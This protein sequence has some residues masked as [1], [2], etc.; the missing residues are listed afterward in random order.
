ME[1]RDRDAQGWPQDCY[2]DKY[3][4]DGIPHPVKN[5]EERYNHKRR[6]AHRNVVQANLLLSCHR[7]P[8]DIP[9]RFET[10]IPIEVDSE[11]EITSSLAWESGGHQRSNVD[12]DQTDGLD[13]SPSSRGSAARSMDTEMLPT[14]F[15]YDL[16]DSPQERPAADNAHDY[17][18]SDDE[19][20]YTSGGEVG[21][22]P[23]GPYSEATIEPEDLEA[24]NCERYSGAFDVELAEQGDQ[25][26]HEANMRLEFPELF[27]LDDNS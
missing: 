16:P 25:S 22:S 4:P 2:C 1:R 13:S 6:Y 10:S 5:K 21:H 18:S 24:Q 3:G 27:D 14:E 19:M 11:D 7:P 8:D 20:G 12:K 26:D 17:D 9:H 15:A 23:D